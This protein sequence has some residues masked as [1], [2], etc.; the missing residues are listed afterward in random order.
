V[1]GH[2]RPRVAVAAGGSPRRIRACRR[3]F[4][5][6]RDELL[7]ELLRLSEDERP[8]GVIVV[9]GPNGIGKTRLALAWLAELGQRRHRPLLP[10]RRGWSRMF[11]PARW[12][13]RPWDVGFLQAEGIE[14]LL[15]QGLF[16][17]RPF[18]PTAV[19]LDATELPGEATWRRA[20]AGLRR[21]AEQYFFPV[22]V[23]VLSY[24]PYRFA[25]VLNE[26]HTSEETLVQLGPLGPNG[27][28]AL[29]A[30]ATQ[31]R[32]LS[33]A[34]VERLMMVTGGVPMLV[35]MLAGEPG[36]WG[37]QPTG[38]ADAQRPV[39]VLFR[40]AERV[41][42]AAKPISFGTEPGR[43]LMPLFEALAIATLARQ[44]EAA[45]FHGFSRA[46]LP[47][48]PAIHMTGTRL[49]G[50]EPP[51]LGLAF[52][53]CVHRDATLA[54]RAAIAQRA[55]QESPEGVASM[56][57]HFWLSVA[58]TPRFAA[59]D[60]L[61]GLNDPLWFRTY[62]LVPAGADATTRL[63]WL[64]TRFDL[65]RSFHLDKEDR[66]LFEHDVTQ[67]VSE[68]QTGGA[69]IEL[70]ALVSL[71][72]SDQACNGDI[73]AWRSLNAL[74]E[75]PGFPDDAV[76]AA[77]RAAAPVAVFH[78][79]PGQAD[80][81]VAL[82]ERYYGRGMHCRNVGRLANSSVGCCCPIAECRAGC[83]GEFDRPCERSF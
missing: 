33:E 63:L 78:L 59:S 28:Q 39:D 2:A 11:H 71:F 43:A 79:L 18:R 81:A 50:I 49:D 16:D 22:R 68:V 10:Q 80:E 74:Y 8:Y 53:F 24:K 15:G 73:A 20:E 83:V 36:W 32:S 29:Y 46:L 48:D 5:E 61:P 45:Q 4:F 52:L 76:G 47:P 65:L 56:L 69:S 66:L 7:H 44:L 17:W 35:R 40:Y 51:L 30:R 55:W 64:A 14:Q 34:E 37:E 13:G 67:A 75:R 70:A 31:R 23:L 6:E 19:V 1:A 41:F 25:H 3:D 62:D 42:E 58:R 60:D 9:V 26:R 57:R 12:K 72:W 77:W 82:L 54:T 38:G 21:Y 27:V